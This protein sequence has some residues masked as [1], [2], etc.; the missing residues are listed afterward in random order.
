MRPPFVTS[1]EFNVMQFSAL[2][3]Y[4]IVR[5]IIILKLLL[6]VELGQWCKIIIRY[7]RASHPC[8]LLTLRYTLSYWLLICYNFGF[9][10]CFCQFGVVYFLRSLP[11]F[12]ARRAEYL[13]WPA[14]RAC[15]EE[16]SV[17]PRIFSLHFFNTPLFKTYF[18]LYL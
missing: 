14:H 18:T 8:Y 5:N 2:I 16:T 11:T 17:S 13:T 1:Y 6:I 4:F 7:V 9:T 3:V 12:L 15:F 10:Y